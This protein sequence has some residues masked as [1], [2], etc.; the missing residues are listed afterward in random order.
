MPYIFN[1]FFRNDV[2]YWGTAFDAIGTSI[3]K[4]IFPIEVHD[5]QLLLVSSRLIQG[6]ADPLL[7]VFLAL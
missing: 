6:F 1:T 3:Q 2:P 5:T 7:C 4:K